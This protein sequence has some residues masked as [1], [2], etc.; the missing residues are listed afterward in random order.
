MV[1]GEHL[2]TVDLDEATTLGKG[3]APVAVS[4]IDL[5][6]LAAPPM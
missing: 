6:M 2:A 3:N 5:S 1:L 4:V